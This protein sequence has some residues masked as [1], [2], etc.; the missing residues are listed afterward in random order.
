MLCQ[1]FR[2]IVVYSLLGPM[3]PVAKDSWPD[4]DALYEFYHWEYNLYLIRKL[5]INLTI[6]VL[7]LY[8]WI[9]LVWEH[10]GS[11]VLLCVV[12]F[13]IIIIHI[14]KIMNDTLC[15]YFL[16]ARSSVYTCVGVCTNAIFKHYFS[17]TNYHFCC[18]CYFCSFVFETRSFTGL[19]FTD[20]IGWLSIQS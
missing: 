3:T 15:V 2:I 19:D 11:P 10:K 5:L 4:N 16:C 17:G 1:L 18:F 6:I 7:L 14:L 9:C 20:W 8:Q 12:G 13:F